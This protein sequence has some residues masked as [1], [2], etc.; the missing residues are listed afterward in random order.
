VDSRSTTPSR[1][2]HAGLVS[3]RRTPISP[4]LLAATARMQAV[5]A[6]RGGVITAA[7]CRALGVDDETVRRLIGRD[8]WV[9]SRHGVYADCA[10]APDTPDPDH[11]AG[12]AALLASLAT[13]AVISHLS[14]ARLLGL[15]LPPGS[16]DPRVCVTRRR[17]APSNDPLLGDVH[18]LDYADADVVDVAG[19]PVLGG[20]RLVLDCCDVLPPDSALAIADA[21]LARDLTSARA[22]RAALRARRTRPEVVE[23][24]V[25]RAD[26]LAESWFES[27]SRWWLQEGGLLRPR[28]QVPFTDRDGRVRAK[29]DMLIGR[30]V[31]EADGAGKYD[32]PGS[33]FAEKQRED[34]LRDSHRVEVVR[35]VPAEMR[36]PARRAEVVGRFTLAAARIR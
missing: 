9:R 16:P 21:A 19:V 35:W 18:V 15:P 11:H 20:A 22:L 29:V 6:M 14:A 3:R 33:L 36:S 13:P 10:F 23:R 27:V 1:L 26:P 24:V 31:G 7:Q 25:E 32:E 2:P 34:W 12:S 17:P 30:V 5:A 4:F 28:L 8:L